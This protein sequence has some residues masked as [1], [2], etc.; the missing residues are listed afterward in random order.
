MSKLTAAEKK[1]LDKLQKVLNECP[2]DRL[3]F[4][5]IGDSY[6]TVFDLTKGD[7][8]NKLQFSAGLDFSPACEKLNAHFDY[9]LIFPSPVESVSR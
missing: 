8:I 6:V 1:W 2:S 7:E 4:Y 3:G 9:E 5:T